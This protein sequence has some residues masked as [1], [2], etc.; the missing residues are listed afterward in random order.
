M[1]KAVNTCASAHEHTEVYNLSE[2]ALREDGI[3]ELERRIEQLR[4]KLRLAVVFGGDKSAAGSVIYESPQR[5]LME[6]L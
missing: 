3:A 6:E 1:S 2:T 4:S 5:A